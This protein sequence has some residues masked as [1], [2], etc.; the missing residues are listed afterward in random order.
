MSKIF[1]PLVQVILSFWKVFEWNRK[2]T[3]VAM[4]YLEQRGCLTTFFYLPVSLSERYITGNQ[5]RTVHR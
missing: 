1:S 4:L 2:F 3:F 5:H